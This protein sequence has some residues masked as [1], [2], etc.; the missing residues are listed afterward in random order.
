MT[1]PGSRGINQWSEK[2][3]LLLIEASKAGPGPRSSL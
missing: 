2:P 1:L 3:E